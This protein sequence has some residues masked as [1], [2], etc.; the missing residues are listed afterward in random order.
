[1]ILKL[2]VSYLQSSIAWNIKPQ[3]HRFAVDNLPEAHVPEIPK[4]SLKSLEW[5][6]SSADG[7]VKFLYRPK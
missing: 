1:M 7:E 3:S 6:G 4:Q 2:N 5:L